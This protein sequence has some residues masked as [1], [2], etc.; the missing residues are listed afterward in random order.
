[1]GIFS[2]IKEKLFGKKTEVASADPITTG[3]VKPVTADSGATA[4]TAGGAA[5]STPAENKTAGSTA[6]AAGHGVVHNPTQPV[7]KG[8]K[9]AVH[10][11]HHRSVRRGRATGHPQ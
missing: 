10:R 2:S 9:M 11:Q 1:M 7:S 5:A 4:S 3:S 6:A 8:V